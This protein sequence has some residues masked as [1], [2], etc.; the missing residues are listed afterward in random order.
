MRIV[1]AAADIVKGKLASGK[2]ASPE[3]VRNWMADN[4]RW[5]VF[6]CPDVL[7]VQ[8]HM[9]NWTAIARNAKAL[10][11]IESAVQRW[12]RNNLLE[13]DCFL[14]TASGGGFPLSPPHAPICSP[15]CDLLLKQRCDQRTRNK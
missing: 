11:L 5:G 7:T 12:G 4:I 10:Q 9:N 3:A 1:A 8:R 15:H 13:I 2:K 14:F 6:S